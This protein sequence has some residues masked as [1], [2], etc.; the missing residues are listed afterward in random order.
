MDFEQ[1]S[2]AIRF[3][4]VEA[5]AL[6]WGSSATEEA[7]TI[8]HSA[9]HGEN[10]AIGVLADYFDDRDHPA[11]KWLRK[12]LAGEAIE[13]DYMEQGL[14]GTMHAARWKEPY[15]GRG[16]TRTP[17]HFAI[18]PQLDNNSEVPNGKATVHNSYYKLPGDHHFVHTVLRAGEHATRSFLIP[19]TPE[20]VHEYA[21][22]L[23]GIEDDPT[24]EHWKG[25]T[26][27]EPRPDR[28]YNRR[29]TAAGLGHLAQPEPAEQFAKAV[30]EVESSR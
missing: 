26:S 12:I 19:T 17:F 27:V 7:A 8:A 29:L 18:L 23:R 9:A 22:S 24:V 14:L 10:T 1:L 25:A 21:E 13:G 30:A 4:A 15:E 5:K 11:S 28:F 6:S 3:G 16:L 20:E 2:G